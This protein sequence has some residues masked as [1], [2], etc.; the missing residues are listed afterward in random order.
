MAFGSIMKFSVGELEIELSPLTKEVMGEYI[1]HEHSG[2][3]QSLAVNRYVSRQTAPTLE[4]ELEWFERTR[5]EKDT[6]VWGIWVKESSG[7]VLIGGTSIFNIGTYGHAPMFRSGETGSMIFRQDYWARGIASAI[8]K[9]RTWY[10]FQHLGL[11]ILK[12]AVLQPNTGSRKALERSGYVVTRTVRNEQYIEGTLY[13]LDWLECL[14]P[15]DLFW[16]L[17]W[18]NESPPKASLDARKVT[19][20]A[21]EWAEKNVTL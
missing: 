6:I 18:H 14:N 5:T 21:M 1:S 13:H 10:A 16:S 2:G 8:H 9:A 17:W 3:I 20:K 7:K 12:S 11:N 19:E 4:D 15:L